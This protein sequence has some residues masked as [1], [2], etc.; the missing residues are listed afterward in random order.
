MNG[1]EES[2]RASRVKTNAATITAA[3]AVEIENVRRSFDCFFFF[4]G[5]EMKEE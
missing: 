4:F 3:A 5:V 1:H 2:G